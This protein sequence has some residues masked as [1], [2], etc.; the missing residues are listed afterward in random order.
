MENPHTS[1]KP[2]S[3]Y[4]FYF[5]QGTNYTPVELFS[6]LLKI[7]VKMFC[8]VQGI[9]YL[10]YVIPMLVSPNPFS[11]RKPNIIALSFNRCLS[12]RFAVYSYPTNHTVEARWL[13]EKQCI[14]NTDDAEVAVNRIYG[15][16]DTVAILNKKVYKTP[17]GI[18]KA[19]RN[20]NI[21]HTVIRR[22]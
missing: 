17:A 7:I 22:I 12:N 21:E 2:I 18:L 14:T 13:N 11:M 5:Y 8:Y 16:F 1:I 6:L 20:M 4:S 19:L 10:H 3:P 15:E 9:A